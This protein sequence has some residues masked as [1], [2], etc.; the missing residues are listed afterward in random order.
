MKDHHPFILQPS[1]WLGEGKINLSLVEEE[2]PFY[3]RWKIQE[4]DDC[5]K[6]ECLQEIQVKGLSE[7]MQ[8]QLLLYD[9]NPGTFVIELD[10][11]ALGRVIGK[12]IVSE[13]LIGWEFR[14]PEAGFEGYEFYEKQPDDSYLMHAEYST[15]DQ[16][17][18]IIK[19]RVW[20]QLEKK[21]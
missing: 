17:R 18:T 8:N 5:G 19:G 12:G 20:K 15:S 16:L 3:T 14:S 21:K 2:L 13:K 1:S 10:N 6:I 4:K 11:P 9:L 7:I